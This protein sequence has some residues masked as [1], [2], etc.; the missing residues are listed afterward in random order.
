MED[1]RSTL[2]PAEVRGGGGTG[3]PPS[4]DLQRPWDQCGPTW[5]GVPFGELNHR[6]TIGR[7]EENCETIGKP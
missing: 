4:D 3:A 2:G 5:V 1:D 7:P 6:K